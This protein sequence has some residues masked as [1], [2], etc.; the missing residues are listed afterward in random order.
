M[1]TPSWRFRLQRWLGQCLI[2]LFTVTVTGGAFVAAHGQ[3]IQQHWSVPHWEDQLF[4]QYVEERALTFSSCFT[5]PNL[6]PGLYRPLTTNCYY[7]VGGQLF[8]QQVELYQLINLV[9]YLL[10][11]LLAGWIVRQLVAWPYA[12]LTTTIF[13]SRQAHAEVVSNTVEFQVL[14]AVCF[15]LLALLFFVR[16]VNRQ[17][18]LLTLPSA[19]CLALALLSK[20]VTMTLV[21]LLLVY[22]WLFAPRFDWRYLLPPM[23]VVGLWLFAMTTYIRNAI[24]GDQPTG[25]QFTLAPEV[26]LQ[27]GAAHLWSFAYVT[28][29]S[30]DNTTNMVMPPRLLQIA[31]SLWGQAALIGLGLS[32][33]LL[34]MLKSKLG[35]PSRVLALGCAFFTLGVLPFLFFEGRLF[36]RYGYFAH[37][38][39]A[40]AAA[41]LA[42][43]TPRWIRNQSLLPELVVEDRACSCP[44]APG[45]AAAP[46][47]HPAEADRQSPW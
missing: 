16:A 1:N 32:T 9:L 40:I 34:L 3:R 2:P 35:P 37:A 19:G 30:A 10:N 47:V 11:A 38:G 31:S 21:F 17:R 43:R 45:A 4:F 41:G 27:N 33:V 25:F 22:L 12:L 29:G 44:G 13:V 24:V 6:W 46:P 36:M 39:L 14:A 23:A 8:G 26:I 28:A 42:V 18:W 7:A 15:A 5:Q 20:E